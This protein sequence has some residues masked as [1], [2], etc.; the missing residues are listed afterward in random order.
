[1]KSF[2]GRW[3]LDEQLVWLFVTSVLFSV[4]GVAIFLGAK[5]GFEDPAKVGPFKHISLI[6]MVVLLGLLF[7]AAFALAFP[8]TIPL[9]VTFWSVS[10][11]MLT[12]YGLTRRRSAQIAAAA[13]GFGFWV[14]FFLIGWDE[15]SHYSWKGDLRATGWLGSISGAAS[16]LAATLIYRREPKSVAEMGCA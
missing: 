2:R 10:F 1:M 14:A 7:F 5:A 4:V 3:G 8:L 15:A 16:A 12:A 6:P 11:R 9:T 13:T